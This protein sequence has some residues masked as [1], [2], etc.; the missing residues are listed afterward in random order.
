MYVCPQCKL[1][2]DNFL[3]QKC[4]Q[5]NLEFSYTERGF[6]YNHD[7]LLFKNFK[8]KYLLNKVLNNNAYISYKFLQE[9][10]L[11]LSGREDVERF[12]VYIQKS[13]PFEQEIVILDIGC[14]LLEKPGYLDFE[15]KNNITF[16]GIEPLAESNFFGHLITGTSEFIPL[17]DKSI[18]NIIFATSLDHVCSIETTIRESFRILKQEGKVVIWMS[19]QSKS[20]CKYIIDKL[21]VWRQNVIKGYRTDHYY[22]YPNYTVLEVPKGGVDPFHSF[23]ESPKVIAKMFKKEGFASIDMQ[24]NSKNEVFLTFQKQ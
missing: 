19:D 3:S 18:D 17:E 20:F 22:V 24:Y 23:F 16:Y 14:G 13:L 12:K 11:S 2:I 15:T 6:S 4:M 8:K 7:E 10:S 21:K 9:G 5:C 1:K